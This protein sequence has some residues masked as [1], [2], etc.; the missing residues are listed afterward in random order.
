MWTP[1]VGHDAYMLLFISSESVKPFGAS[2]SFGIIT[3]LDVVVNLLFLI[4][5]T[6]QTKINK[7]K[8]TTGEPTAVVRI[9]INLFVSSPKW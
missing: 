9:I 2:V 7:R 3:V 6:K 5:N 8:S 1:L 4:E